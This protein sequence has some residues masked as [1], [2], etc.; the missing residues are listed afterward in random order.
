MTEA[1]IPWAIDPDTGAIVDVHAGILPSKEGYRCLKCGGRLVIYQGDFMIRHFRHY[2]DKKA[3]TC[4]LYYGGEFE[5]QKLLRELQTSDI[6]KAESLKQIRL[7]VEPKA[8]GRTLS[9]YGVL[10]AVDRS[11]V[12]KGTDINRVLDSLIFNQRGIRGRPTGHAFH[13]SEPEAR[14]EMDPSSKEYAL[15]ITSP[16][17]ALRIVGTWKAAGLKNGDVFRGT[18]TSAE[19]IGDVNRLAFG[20]VVFVLQG[21]QPGSMPPGTELYRLGPWFVVSFEITPNSVAYLESLSGMR[22]PDVRP[23]YVDVVIPSHVDPSSQTPIMGKP[24]APVLIAISPPSDADPEFEVVSVPLEKGGATPIPKSGAGKPRWYRTSFPEKDPQRLSIHWADRHRAVILY[25]ETKPEAY[26]GLAARMR[27]EGTVD[28]V[29][30]GE[31]ANRVHSWDSS[32]VTVRVNKDSRRL[33]DSGLAISAPEGIK[34]DVMASFPAGARVGPTVRRDD[35]TLQGLEAEFYAWVQEGATK[36]VLDFDS[37][38][39]VEISLRGSAVRAGI[40]SKEEIRALIEKM[41]PLPLAARWSLVRTICGAKPGTLHLIF[42]GLKKRVR[43]A[44]ME[45]R[46]NRR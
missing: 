26:P 21:L 35:S 45:V 9:F 8:Y 42:P 37:L 33:Q 36:I 12:P 38:G 29:V 4:P 1:K 7:V 11:E 6:E 30:D 28:I 40:I 34:F 32:P 43:R 17:V 15:E 39:A 25:G 22:V 3:E 46:T 10:P 41:D 16:A 31:S 44:L 2:G 24:G 14:L 19:R 27:S 23:F 20:D 5:K 18:R 13:P